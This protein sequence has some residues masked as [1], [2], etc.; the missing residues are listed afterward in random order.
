[1]STP[2]PLG[3]VPSWSHV[4]AFFSRVNP[5][6]L[7]SHEVRYTA[8][9]CQ[10]VGWIVLATDLVHDNVLRF[11][12][13]LDPESHH[14]QWLHIARSLSRENAFSRECIKTQRKRPLLMWVE[15][16]DNVAVAHKSSS[17]LALLRG[18]PLHLS[19]MQP[20]VERA[21]NAARNVCRATTVHHSS[22]DV[23]SGPIGICT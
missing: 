21:S 12:A 4:A 14:V 9:A 19:L 2:P 5:A 18:L 22:F 8:G 10:R 13:L 23:S 15:F 11:H 3:H 6:V 20:L 17:H 16:G 7:S 1:M